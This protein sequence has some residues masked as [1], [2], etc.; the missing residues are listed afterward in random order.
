M[1]EAPLL[2]LQNVETYYGP[3][4]AIRGISLEVRAGQDIE[5]KI[6]VVAAVDG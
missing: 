2:A 3:V 1:A 6:D 5:G 4:M